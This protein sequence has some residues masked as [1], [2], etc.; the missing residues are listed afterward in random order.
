MNDRKVDIA[1]IGA[2]IV[3]IACAYYLARSRPGLRIVIV[4]QNAPMSLIRKNGAR[5]TGASTRR[6]TCPA[7]ALACLR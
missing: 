7:I 1:V 3:G 6:S 2:G 5:S 4:D